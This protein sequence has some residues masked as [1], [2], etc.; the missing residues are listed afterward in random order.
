MLGLGIPGSNGMVAAIPAS[1][2]SLGQGDALRG[3]PFVEPAFKDSTRTNSAR[4]LNLL[5]QMRAY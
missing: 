3:L 4:R 2:R 1:E 5:K